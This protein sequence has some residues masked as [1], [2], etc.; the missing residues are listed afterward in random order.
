MT[1]AREG[2]KVVISDI[3]EKGLAATA[4]DIKAEG[5]TVLAL[6]QDAS[7]EDDWKKV[8]PTTLRCPIR[9]TPKAS[10]R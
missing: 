2:A 4:K 9:S 6:R 5:G 8:Q 3:D 10:A 1:L 7:S